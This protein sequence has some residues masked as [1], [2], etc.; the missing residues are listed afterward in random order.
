MKCICIAIFTLVIFLG[1]ENLFAQS[2]FNRFLTPADTFNKNK[3]LLVASSWATIYTAS[4]IGLSTV[5]YN[6]YEKTSFHFFNDNGE[7]L[8]MDK[9]GHV[10][11][12]YF[13]SIYTTTALQWAGVSEKKSAIYGAAT[14]FIFQ[15]TLE[16]F[17]GFSVE[18]GASPGDI[19]ANAVGSGISLSQFLL[20]NEQRIQIKF[21]A[22]NV[23]YT[24]DLQS[25][26]DDLFGTS[27]TENILKDYNGQTYWLS[28]NPSYFIQK[29]NS[30]F[31]KWLNIA[32]G[33][34][35]E[36][37]LAGFNNVWEENGEAVDRSDVQRARQ[38][39]LSPDIDF[40]RI[41]TRS[42]TLKTL[43][44]LMNIVKIPAPALEMNSKG[45]VKFHALY[46]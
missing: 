33:Y 22:H 28:V 27:F 30:K 41:K 14:G 34:G 29:E 31:P 15:T 18:W 19:L 7:W 8:Q 11:S 20:W 6:D 36:G 12:A 16:I 43:F 42:A 10:Y 45:V 13:Q 35:A 9:A 46:F 3:T 4:V 44:S 2:S 39:Y 5:W 25:R 24:D 40:T 26:T 32:A 17:D 23:S 21:S 1:N 38:F 37:M